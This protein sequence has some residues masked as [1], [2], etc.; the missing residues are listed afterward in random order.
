MFNVVASPPLP[1]AVTSY[2]STTLHSLRSICLPPLGRGDRGK[3]KE[4]K[5][6]KKL[7]SKEKNVDREA[8]KGRRKRRIALTRTKSMVRTR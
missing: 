6:K 1:Q 2:A 7:R 5:G 8:A 4:G 3:E